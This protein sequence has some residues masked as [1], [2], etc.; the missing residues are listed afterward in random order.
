MM[1]DGL[2]LIVHLGDYVYESDWGNKVRF[3]P[4]EP[5]TLD[6][7][8]NLHALYKSDPHLQAAHAWHPFAVTWDDHEVDN[9]Y[10]G[11]NSED[12]LTVEQFLRR[13]AAAYQAYYEHMPLRAKARPVGPDMTLFTASHFG[14]L[15]TFAILDNR[16]YRSDQ[17]C[18]G[19]EKFGG[20]LIENCAERDLEE[21]AILGAPQ[22]RWLVGQL[23]RSPAKWKVIGQQMLMAQLDQKA[24]D[25]KAWWSDGWDGYP[26]ARRRLLTQIA[27]RK[28]ANVVVIGGDLHSFWVTDLKRDFDDLSSPVVATEFVG[29]SVTSAG[30][31]YDQ[32]RAFL[33]E[34]PHIKFFDSRP[35]GYGLVEVTQAQWRTELRTVSTVTE[36]DATVA[37][38][39]SYVVESD[40]PGAQEA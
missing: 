2:D 11:A 19:P 20:Q 21:R 32:F 25:G 26:A 23:S 38:L 8:R 40:V 34:N 37:T 14:D 17:A 6:D 15:A 5:T 4:P 22:E 12:R 31:D 3:H 29:T 7:Y 1:G 18:Q 28:I 36:P 9:D 10:A 33:P 30:P 35:R 13:R 27:D 39:R 16:Q 24:G